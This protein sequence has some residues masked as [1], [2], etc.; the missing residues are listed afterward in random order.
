MAQTAFFAP[1]ADL[2]SLQRGEVDIAHEK[3]VTRL[4]LAQAEKLE[5]GIAADK[6]AAERARQRA[7]ASSGQP[8]QPPT[9]ESISQEMLMQSQDYMQ[10]GDLA[11]SN[12]MAQQAT[13]LL[14]HAAAT[15][16]ADAD[17]R[18]LTMQ[19]V[20]N[21]L[22]ELY[23]ATSTIKSPLQWQE[24][25]NQVTQRDP[26]IAQD[27]V[28]QQVAKTPW[29]QKL[30]DE[31]GKRSMTA[32]QQ[33]MLDA[34]A[35]EDA[36]REEERKSKEALR[37]SAEARRERELQLKEQREE[38]LAKVGGKSEKAKLPPEIRKQS[39]VV[40]K[41]QFP[42]LKNEEDQ[43]AMS[44]VVAQRAAALMQQNRGLDQA[45]AVYRA[46][47]EEGKNIESRVQGGLSV[48]GHQIG[49][50]TT[51]QYSGPGSKPQTALPMTSTNPKDY[52]SGRWYNTPK[53]PAYFN[54]RTFETDPKKVQVDK[55]KPPAED[56][57]D[58]ELE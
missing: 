9:L 13:T 25:L 29:S 3:A 2:Q 51:T 28:F 22:K 42:D 38:R 44:H 14:Q 34:R 17:Q 50:K 4:D 43:Q 21:D 5:T 53:G 27:P 20:T 1:Y 26:E 48:L 37:A 41:Q 39:L 8:P 52:I 36:A 19:R 56:Y 54:G 6:F 55:G 35:K 32:Y 49:G 18:R 7:A 47:Q 46:V 57:G 58:E 24:Y 45:T 30:M 15:R 31:L 40:L 12:A 16:K 11:K 10:G 23:Q 33:A